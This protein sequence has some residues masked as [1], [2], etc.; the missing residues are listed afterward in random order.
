MKLKKAGKMGSK[1]HQLRGMSIEEFFEKFSTE[2]QCYNY[3][4]KAK[5]PNGFI[6]PDCGHNRAFELKTRKV[7]QCSKCHFQ[8]TLKADTIFAS[9][10]LSLRKWFL[11]IHL[12]TINKNGISSI[13]LSRHLGVTQSTAWKMKHKL[14]QTMMERQTKSKLGGIVEIDDAY[15]GGEK[16]GGKRGR[17]S[18]NK[19]PF[20]AAVEK[21][22]D[23]PMKISLRKVS[24]FT[25]KELKNWATRNLLD[26]TL[27]ASDGFKCFNGIEMAGYPHIPI[28]TGSGKKS[29]TIF[30]WVNTILGNVKNSISG[31]YHLI[32]AKHIP[33]Y[34]AEFEYKFNRRYNLKSLFTRLVIAAAR[35]TP[36]PY[37]LL[38]LAEVPI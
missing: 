37:R 22:D 9:T 21:D 1:I 35:T 5:W 14:M 26:G 28:K 11:A 30:K 19:H 38:K 12:I 34:L 17:G 29:C 33:R 15:I 27:V 7:Y 36:M 25:K 18:E 3:L 31:T 10:K 8:T 24:G 4:K 6:C 23:K 2:T 32:R 16:T 20:V 13:E